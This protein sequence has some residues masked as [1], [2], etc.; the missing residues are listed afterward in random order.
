[1]NIVEGKKLKELGKTRLHYESLADELEK[2][3]SKIN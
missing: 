1:M 3:V 2:N